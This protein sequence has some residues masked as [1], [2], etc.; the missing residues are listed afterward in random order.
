MISILLSAVA[1]ATFYRMR[2]GSP[3]WPRPIEQC[4][5]CLIYAMALAAA[6]VAWW[7]VALAYA[8]AVLGCC[9]GH[10][11]YMSFGDVVKKI[12][13]ETLDFIIKPFFG[14]DYR[15]TGQPP[16]PLYWRCVAGLAVTGMAVTLAP[17]IAMATVNH[18]A[19]A[20]IMVSGALKAP[21]YMLAHAIGRD[22]GELGKTELGEYMTGAA[23]WALA[24]IIVLY[25]F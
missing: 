1:G 6:G 5:Y 14:E 22:K 11:Q 18:F 20:G 19:G 15:V 21:A 16:S 3:S 13:P 8:L 9:T 17:G 10:G 2:G 24:T 12:K 23:S 25:I 7:G 4:L